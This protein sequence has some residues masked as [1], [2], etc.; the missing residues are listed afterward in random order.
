MWL[1]RE[2]RGLPNN[3]IVEDLALHALD[4]EPISRSEGRPLLGASARTQTQ[5]Q[6]LEGRHAALHCLQFRIVANHPTISETVGSVRR[7]ECSVESFRTKVAERERLRIA[8]L[9]QP[10]S[11]LPNRTDTGTV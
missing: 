5:Q 2:R 9:R 6:L 10:D 3:E 1:A 7:S 4:F 8:L 11:S